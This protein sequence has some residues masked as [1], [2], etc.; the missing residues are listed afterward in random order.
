MQPKLNSRGLDTWPGR[1]AGAD[2]RPPVE[3]WLQIS[4]PAP[5]VA[6]CLLCTLPSRLPLPPACPPQLTWAP[7]A[8]MGGFW[9][10]DPHTGGLQGLVPSRAWF[11]GLGKAGPERAGKGLCPPSEKTGG[12]LWPCCPC[13]S[14]SLGL[15]LPLKGVISPSLCAFKDFEICII[16]KKSQ[17]NICSWFK[18]ET[19]ENTHKQK[20]KNPTICCSRCQAYPFF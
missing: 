17:S 1:E 7:G 20:S 9:A 16:K 2:G 15:P 19:F 8:S 11:S 18:V 13:V 6:P 14:D 5:P 10:E 12:G 3:G 4:A